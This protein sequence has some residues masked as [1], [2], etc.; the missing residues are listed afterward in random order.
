MLIINPT[1]MQL[2]VKAILC[3]NRIPSCADLY[4]VN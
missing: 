1:I 4:N 3:N 2:L